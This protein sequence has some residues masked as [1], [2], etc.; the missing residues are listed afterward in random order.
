MEGSAGAVIAFAYFV[1]FAVLCVMAGV[2]ALGLVLAVLELLC[3]ALLDRR[4]R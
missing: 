3:W 4:W 1:S 2:F